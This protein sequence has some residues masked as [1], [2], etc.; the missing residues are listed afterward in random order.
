VDLAESGD[1][2]ETLEMH[3]LRKSI[4]DKKFWGENGLARAM[5]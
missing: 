5:P 1:E 4:Y 3:E 2:L